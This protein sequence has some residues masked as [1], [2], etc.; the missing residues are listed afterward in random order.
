MGQYPRRHRDPLTPEQSALAGANV[1]L[2]PWVARRMTRARPWL[3]EGATD[4]AVDELLKAAA[5][6]DPAWGVKFT[7]FA[8]CYMRFGIR[9]YFTYVN[10]DCRRAASHTVNLDEIDLG[11]LGPS[12]EPRLP[13][14]SP[15]LAGLLAPL[16]PVEREVLAMRYGEGITLREVAGR[17]GFS[18]Q[19]AY[20]I[21][22]RAL[23]RLGPE[24][25]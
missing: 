20:Q 3:L 11:R 18:K 10:R 22:R 15:D 23:A 24:G 25:Y 12:V 17:L 4:S 7:T 5:D 6:F 9:N 1:R 14:E 13:D 16:P 19:R 2:A 21:Q 8:S